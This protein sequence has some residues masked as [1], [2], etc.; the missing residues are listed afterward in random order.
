MCHGKNHG[1]VIPDGN[2]SAESIR[3]S[4]ETLKNDGPRHESMGKPW[5][6]SLGFHGW[7]ISNYRFQTLVYGRLVSNYSLGHLVGNWLLTNFCLK[8]SADPCL[9]AVLSQTSSWALFP[10]SFY[11]KGGLKRGLQEYNFVSPVSSVGNPRHLRLGTVAA[12]SKNQLR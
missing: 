2:A 5:M 8:I 10:S 3:P 11:L 1:R 4:Q 9:L 6:F 7:L 12:K